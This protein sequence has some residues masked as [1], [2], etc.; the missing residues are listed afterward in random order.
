MSEFQAVANARYSPTKCA[1][2]DTHAGPFID[3]GF[4]VIGYGHVYIC[5][6]N[7]DH[8]GCV[9][10]MARLDNMIDIEVV[11]DALA[12][13]ERLRAHVDQL[14][15]EIDEK[16]TAPLAEILDEMRRRRGGRPAKTQPPD[17]GEPEPIP[18]AEE[19]V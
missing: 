15:A 6:A 2:C 3:T 8:S 5:M 7:K 10:Q 4:E 18:T 13:T 11:T 19:K 17:L 12:E 16:W 14:Q 9:R 1:L